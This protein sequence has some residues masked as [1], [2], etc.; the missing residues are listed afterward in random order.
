MKYLAVTCARALRNNKRQGDARDSVKKQLL[1]T[2]RPF[3]ILITLRRY[4]NVAHWADT[5]RLIDVYS[6]EMSAEL[7]NDMSRTSPS[8]LESTAPAWLAEQVYLPK[9][10]RT[11]DLVQQSVEVLRREKARISL[12][13]ITAKSRELDPTGAGI[14]ESAILTN[15]AARA[16]YEQHRN[17]KRQR[18]L[19]TSP[20]KAEKHI[21]TGSIKLTRDKVRARQ[22]YHRLSKEALVDRLLAAEHNV[23]ELEERWLS[24]QDDVLI[25][26]FRAEAAEKRLLLPS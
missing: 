14:S 1:W 26:R 10:Q 23:A 17:W 15:E 18:Q 9:R 6:E 22:R 4:S 7:G 2:T 20:Q 24:H 16:C 25:F 3:P 5:K 12:A 13:S 19:P 21:P 8:N 11:I